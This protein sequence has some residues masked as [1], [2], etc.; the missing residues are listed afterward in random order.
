MPAAPAAPSNPTI[1]E[2]DRPTED[3][4]ATRADCY[5]RPTP[6]IALLFG[7]SRWRGG[8]SVVAEGSA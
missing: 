5:A 4:A 7:R 6:A 1:A 2:L 8:R 3:S